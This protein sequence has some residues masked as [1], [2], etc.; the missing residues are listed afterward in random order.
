MS[1]DAREI[2]GRVDQL[3]RTASAAE[4][5][6]ASIR[7]GSKPRLVM[8]QAFCDREI[9]LDRDATLAIYEALAD[10]RDRSK[11]QADDLEKRITVQEVQR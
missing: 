1:A 3:R 11:R 7:L 4:A 10:V 6:R 9:T 5:F 2:L 8:R